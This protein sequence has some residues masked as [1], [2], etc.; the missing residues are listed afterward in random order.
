V[1]PVSDLTPSSG[2]RVSRSSRE[3]RAYRLVLVGGT[4]AAVSV[5][6][7]VLAVAGVMGYGLF[8]ISA[9]VAVVCGF[10]FRRSVAR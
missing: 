2:R 9:I 8:L 7:F 3:R 6:T 5:V 1:R 10:L 4:A